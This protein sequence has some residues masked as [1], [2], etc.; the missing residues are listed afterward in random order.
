LLNGNI[1][2]EI[3]IDLENK[4]AKE[5]DGKVS[6]SVPSSKQNIG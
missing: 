3:A 1:E 4:K 5:K 2:S 6:E